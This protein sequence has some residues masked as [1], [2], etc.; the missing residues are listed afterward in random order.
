MHVGSPLS[1]P[2]HPGTRAIPELAGVRGATVSSQ[3]IS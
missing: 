1:A 3:V 2:G